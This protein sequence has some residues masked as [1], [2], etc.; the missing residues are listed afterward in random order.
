M[1]NKQWEEEFELKLNEDI[2]E[3][4]FFWSNGQLNIERLKRYFKEALSTARQEERKEIVEKI[5]KVQ[6]KRAHTYSSE[7]AEVYRAYDNGQEDMKSHILSS[8]QNKT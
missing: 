7:N 5:E 3:G 1:E 6:V 4:G 2:Y 8:L